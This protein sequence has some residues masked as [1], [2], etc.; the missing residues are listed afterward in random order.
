LHS[1]VALASPPDV[2]KS[3]IL[4]SVD[5]FK[6]NSLEISRQDRIRYAQFE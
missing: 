6:V 4:L 1:Q 5:R 3:K 2:M